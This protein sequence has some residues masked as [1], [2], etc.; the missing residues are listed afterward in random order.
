MVAAGSDLTN[1]RGIG[2][3]KRLSYGNTKWGAARSFSGKVLR[4]TPFLINSDCIRGSVFTGQRPIGC[5]TIDVNSVGCK[6]LAGY[7]SYMPHDSPLYLTY[8][9]QKKTIKSIGYG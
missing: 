4:R 7:L 6:V 5:I 2:R 8:A 3:C 1:T 9:P